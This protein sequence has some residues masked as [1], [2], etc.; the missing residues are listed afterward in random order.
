MKIFNVIIALLI[1]AGLNYELFVIPSMVNLMVSLYKED[2]KVFLLVDLLISNI[3]F[4]GVLYGLTYLTHKY[5]ER[6]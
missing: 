3:V 6:R 4:L 5:S 2:N 1:T